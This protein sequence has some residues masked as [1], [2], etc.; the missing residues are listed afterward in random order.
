MA[1]EG[2]YYPTVNVLMQASNCQNAAPDASFALRKG[3][4]HSSRE[5]PNFFLVTFYG[6]DWHS[7]VLKKKY[8]NW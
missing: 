3:K 2:G 8:Q 6:S 7:A 4:G 5:Q 1:G